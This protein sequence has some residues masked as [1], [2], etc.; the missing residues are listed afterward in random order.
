MG[1]DWGGAGTL[2]LRR[3]L[4]DR[5]PRVLLPSPFIVL[6]KKITH[7]CVIEIYMH[8]NVN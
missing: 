7:D 3:G 6:E 4:P 1:A 2:K 8:D 5:F